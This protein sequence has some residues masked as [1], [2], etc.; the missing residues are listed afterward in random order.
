MGVETDIT[1]HQRGVGLQRISDTLPGCDPLHFSLLFPYGER[2]WHLVVQY[3]GDATSHNSNRVSY[4]E[5]AVYR[6]Y[7]KTVASCCK[8]TSKQVC[9]ADYRNECV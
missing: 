2:G 1:L 9:H 3:Q 7:I 4:L 6:L 8:V 5:F